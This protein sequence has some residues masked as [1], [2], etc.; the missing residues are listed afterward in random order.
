MAS[1]R[2]GRA[3]DTGERAYYTH[4]PPGD[5]VFRVAARN[6][7]GV[8]SLVDGTLPITVVPPFYRRWWFFAL[9]V[10]ITLAIL[11]LLWNR[12]TQQ[13]ARE[14][15]SQQAFSRELLASQESE[16]RR[17][18]AELHDSLGQRMIII[19]NLALFLLKTK[20]KSLTED[21]K[22]QTI[23]EISS[24]ATQAIEETRAISYALRPFQL[25]RLGLAKAIQ[26]MLTKVARASDIE[27]R[28]DIE[29][30]DDAF[31]E[32]SR[33]NIYRIVQEG[34]NNI[35]KHAQATRGTV[36]ARRDRSSVVLTIS[37]NGQG[38]PSEPRPTRPGTGGFGLTGIR[39]RAMLMNGTLQIKS[40]SGGGTLLVLHFPLESERAT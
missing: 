30:I 8:Q 36:T 3:L 34:V 6:S 2:G 22:Q 21:D 24:E 12:R 40:E 29:D 37:D 31:P 16:R 18:A 26:A 11:W 39:E 5:Y 15:A 28:A 13:T 19:N 1:T 9:I 14:Q 23:E 38:L 27:L 20:G 7:D 33:I 10:L 35:V 25:D 32:D 4:L 17:I